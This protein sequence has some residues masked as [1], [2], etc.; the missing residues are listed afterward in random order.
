MSITNRSDFK[1][2]VL[3]RLGAPVQQINVDD[4]QVEDRIDD[5]LQ[6]FSDY[7][8][9]GS[10]KLMYKH[11][12]TQEDIDNKYLTIPEH[13]SNIESVFSMNS[14]G[15]YGGALFNIRYHI[16]INEVFSHQFTTSLVPYYLAM[17]RLEDMNF[18]FDTKPSIRFNKHTGRLDMNIDW[19]SVSV[20]NFI[21]C[22]A[23]GFV[24]PNEYER[25][26][27]DRWLKEYATQLVKRQW[28]EN[29]KVFG[30]IVLLNGITLNGKEIYDEADTKIQQM[31]ETMI[32]KFSVP[33]LD[34][35]G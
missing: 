29:L 11:Q 26:W 31:E 17:R 22:E 32:N 21:L 15:S 30:G 9:A 27:D 8:Y 20:D 13:I 14:N 2:Y 5:A 16:T 19:S 34:E 24:D 6:Y 23:V 35:I 33:V 18:L 12:I 28:G 7:H 10:Q 1:D 25:V 3:R 4:E